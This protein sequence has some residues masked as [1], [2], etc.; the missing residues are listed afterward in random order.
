MILMH[1]RALSPVF[2]LALAL[3]GC[4]G[5]GPAPD[6]GTD[7]FT[8][9]QRDV[10]DVNCLGAGCHNPQSQAGG[11]VLSEGFSYDALVNTDPTNPAALAAGLLRVTPFDTAN[12]F[13]VIKLTEPG[14]G[15]GDRMPQGQPP[16][17]PDD[18]DIVNQWILNGAPP[19]QTPTGPADATATPSATL[20]ATPTNTP[21]LPTAT[22]TSETGT[23]PTA[24]TPPDVTATA[25]PSPT[26]TQAVTFAEVQSQ[27]FTPNCLTAFCHTASA[28]AGGLVLEDGASYAALVNVP[29]VNIDAMS[30]G[31][32]RVAPD[33]PEASFL[34]VKLTGPTLPQGSRMPL[35]QA[36]LPDNLI[37]LVR[38]WIEQGA[39]P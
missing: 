16:L 2:A 21:P 12:S 35:G 17:S 19:A 18:L 22:P 14:A 32:L 36:P 13:L 33:D 6:T 15:Q 30:N 11:L 31:L 29:A 1:A 28:Q 3:A 7:W 20:S 25:S 10:L 26:A 8:R 24:T 4:A 39:Q 37:A 23:S 34:Y 38:A 9:L 27:V 5:D